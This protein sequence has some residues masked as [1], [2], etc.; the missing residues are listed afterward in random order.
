MCKLYS[1]LGTADRPFSSWPSSPLVWLSHDFAQHQLVRASDTRPAA[2][3]A[4]LDVH[5]CDFNFCTALRAVHSSRFTW[6]ESKVRSLRP[7]PLLKV[8]GNSQREGSYEGDHIFEGDEE[9]RLR[10]AAKCEIVSTYP[11]I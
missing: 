1:V 11:G 7:R 4:V 3:S 6:L 8:K 9:I 5:D 10:P 2:F